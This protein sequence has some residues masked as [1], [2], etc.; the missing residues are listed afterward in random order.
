MDMYISPWLASYEVSIVRILKNIDRVITAPYCICNTKDY[1]MPFTAHP[2]LFI[3]AWYWLI[4]PIYIKV[5][6]L[7]FRQQSD[8]QWR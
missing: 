8:M 2:Y 4:L 3:A 5:I 1:I 6:S 7:A